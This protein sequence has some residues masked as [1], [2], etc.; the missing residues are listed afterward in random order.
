VVVGEGASGLPLPGASGTLT[1]IYRGT[2][3]LPH[4]LLLIN[5]WMA[6]NTHTLADPADGDYADWFELYNPGEVAVDLFGYRLTDNLTN[7]AKFVIPAGWS[8]PSGG[9]LLVWADEESYRNL[10][11]T[12][13]HVNFKLSRD[14]ERIALCHPDGS[15][16]DAVEFGPQK[17]DVS[18]GRWPDGIADPLVSFTVP[19]PASVNVNDDLVQPLRTTSVPGERQ[20]ELVLT[21]IVVPGSKYRLQSATNLSEPN[22][23]D[24]PNS[25]GE[26][27]SSL[28][29][30]ATNQASFFRLLKP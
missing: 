3:P 22:W 8:I 1:V 12:N 17:D 7:T 27:V 28:R 14:G 29:L 10:A 18:Q 20:R 25:E 26:G 13:L 4:P 16:V 24:V 15:L 19:T 9:Y 23:Q 6:A 5:E 11:G 30:L 21:W 2:T